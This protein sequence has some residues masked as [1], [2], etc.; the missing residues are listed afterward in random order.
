MPGLEGR[1]LGRYHI[2]ERL[3]EGGM[4]A[5]YKAFDTRLERNVA[6]KVVLESR[7]H[8]ETFRKR[9][10][11]EA[12][13]L[14]QLSH[15]N[16]LHVNDFGEENGLLYLVMDYIPGGT[17]KKIM[18]KPMN[19]QAAA[20][21]IIPLARALGTA[22]KQGIIHRDVKPANI[23]MTESGE[24]MLS[25]FGIAKL[26]AGEETI[27]LTG[28]G[29]GVGTPEYMAPEQ[30]LNRNVD[31]RADIYAL[32]TVFYELVTG[33]KPYRADTPLA[34]MLMRASEPLPI[35]TQFIP[36]LPQAVEQVILKSLAK[37]PEN[38]YQDAAKFAEALENL[39]HGTAP[40]K[41]GQAKKSFPY[42]IAG[43]AITVLAIL[44]GVL[45]YINGKNQAPAEEPSA[46]VAATA[47]ELPATES[48]QSSSTAA[49][50]PEL[51]S[52]D[53]MDDFED[54]QFD[55][56]YNSTKWNCL[57][58][59]C[60][61][62]I[63]SQEDG[64]LKVAKSNATPQGGY[65][66]GARDFWKFEEVS[67]VQTEFMLE[68]IIGNG[69]ELILQLNVIRPGLDWYTSCNVGDGYFLCKV[70]TNGIDDY[71]TG[72]VDLGYGSW[73]TA[74]IKV[75]PVTQEL[76][77]HLDDEKIGSYS[78]HQL[79][80]IK[81]SDARITISAYSGERGSIVGYV[82]DL[83]VVL[84]GQQ[85]PEGASQP[86]GTST[87][88]GVPAGRDGIAMLSVPAGK[89]Q[90]GS[91][92]KNSFPLHPVYLDAFWLDETEV[93]NE[94]ISAFVQQTGYV[95]DAENAGA[96]EVY[97]GGNS[98][99]NRSGVNWLHPFNKT[100]TLNGMEKY[101]AVHISWND[102]RAY[103]EW[104][105]ER[106]PT[107]AEWEK[108]ARGP[109]GYY[110]PWGNIQPNDDPRYY[111]LEIM[112]VGTYPNEASGYGLLDMGS[113]VQEWTS[114]WYAPLTGFEAANPKGLP[115]EPTASNAAGRTIITFPC[116][117]A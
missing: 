79:S 63:F 77:F 31:H 73:H 55:G 4:A 52:P 96:S 112:P 40:E 71:A 62:E 92:G 1:S 8:S 74:G 86:S 48:I 59:S 82:D 89:F 29:V 28:T 111:H 38:R 39:L 102:A 57:E 91:E 67:I 49:A 6:I 60:P 47:A 23:L 104:A 5:V 35:P 106:L 3:G 51:G 26:M 88:E 101:P 50:S 107:E 54:V 44:A 20:K 15:P 14:A 13:A 87:S 18:G 21:L 56:A 33:R 85:P 68:S 11:R 12:K 76:S 97:I 34:V 10:V 115:A 90:M 100:D 53:F 27:D 36:N 114:D 42:L 24:P 110:Y 64:R 95:T 80:E 99:A 7:Q 46:V 9:F 70:R 61:S 32:G 83:Q 30:G 69:Q 94:K 17:L 103:C 22:H 45:F 37:Q 43:G 109:E 113:N 58:T 93:T 78:P 117:S 19:W 72:F 65:Q 41:T 84:R 98:I 116:F 66:L 81:G 25:D 16:I 75:D 2:L 105:G 108:A